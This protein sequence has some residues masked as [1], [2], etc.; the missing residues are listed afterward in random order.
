V[1]FYKLDNF[2]YKYS[3][4]AAKS[5]FDNKKLEKHCLKESRKDQVSPNFRSM[6]R[7]KD[8]RSFN[9]TCEISKNSTKS[10]NSKNNRKCS[11]NSPRQNP[12][13]PSIN[14]NL[15]NV[16]TKFQSNQI[17]GLK[18]RPTLKS[19]IQ[20]YLPKRFKSKNEIC[21]I[22]RS[23]AAKKNSFANLTS[24]KKHNSIE[25]NVFK[26]ESKKCIPSTKETASKGNTAGGRI[27]TFNN[28]VPSSGQE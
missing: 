15:R 14:M 16:L 1:S 5:K 17:R 10:V 25:R 13:I 3:R 28:N 19:T 7:A 22:S 20:S 23:D 12:K 21:E 2:N 18:K 24:F 4:I 11:K 9:N 27:H 26:A 6:V 8:N